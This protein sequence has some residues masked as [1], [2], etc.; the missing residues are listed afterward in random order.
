MD[1][2]NTNVLQQSILEAVDTIVSRRVKEVNYDKTIVG[3]INSFAEVRNKRNVYKINYNGGFFNAI[4]LNEADSYIP[5]TPVYIHV[6]QGDFTKEKIILSKASNIDLNSKLDILN[7]VSN[8][9][10]TIGKNNLIELDST[11]FPI[12]LHSYHSR[13]N[14]ST[15]DP[16]THRLQKLYSKNSENNI[17]SIEN[18]DNLKRY[19]N[20]KSASALMIRADF[21]TYLPLEQKRQTA[22]KYGLHFVL[23]FNNTSSDWGITQWDALNKAGSKIKAK[24]EFSKEEISFNSY[25]DK[26]AK[27]IK[28][29]ENS[30]SEIDLQ[31][32]IFNEDSQLH[33]WLNEMQALYDIFINKPSTEDKEIIQ[34]IIL[35]FFTELNSYFSF[36][37]ENIEDI[38]ESFNEWKNIKLNTE[39]DQIVHLELNSNKMVGSPL[40][41]QNWTS[42]Y[43]IF[44]L[45]LSN[46][47][48]IE[49]IYFYKDG[50][51]SSLFPDKD[52]A[53]IF[54]KNIGFYVLKPLD[55]ISGDYSLKVESLNT[56]A[57]LSTAHNE[58]VSFQANFYRKLEDLSQNTKLTYYWFKEDPSI[59]IGEKYYN[60]YG[61]KGWK[62]IHDLSY[63]SRYFT[64]DIFENEAYKNLYKCVAVFSEN[65]DSTVIV[66]APFT[67][68]NSDYGSVIELSTDSESIFQTP[69]IT[70]LING[71]EI[72]EITD[73]QIEYPLKFYWSLIPKDKEEIF[74][75]EQP[76]LNWTNLTFD[77][78]TT[79]INQDQYLKNIKFYQ[80]ENIL[81]PAAVDGK[82]DTTQAT[83]IRYPITNLSP[84]EILTIKCTVVKVLTKNNQEENSQEIIEVLLGTG[85]TKLENRVTGTVNGYRIEFE[86]DNQVFQYDEY[87]NS[88]ALNDKLDTL[89]ILPIRARLIG[90][91]GLEI[92]GTNVK[93]DWIF[94]LENTMIIP[95]EEAVL[96]E[97]NTKKILSNSIN[98][99]FNI[100]N[101]YNSNAINNQITCHINFNGEDYYKQTNLFFRKIGENGSNGTDITVHIRPTSTTPL[102]DSQPLTLYTFNDENNNTLKGFLNDKYRIDKE[103]DFKD[104]IIIG[105]DS[106]NNSGEIP[107]LT[108]DVFQKGQPLMSDSYINYWNL[109]GNPSER[110]ISKSKNFVLNIDEDNNPPILQWYYN[111]NNN[112]N[113]NYYNI[114]IIKSHIVIS[115][116]DKT[117]QEYYG[118]YPLPIIYYKNKDDI[119]EF[120]NNRLG[121]SKDYYLKEVTYNADGRNPIYNHNQG[122]KIINLPDWCNESNIKIIA[123]GGW[124]KEEN[125]PDF[126]ILEEETIFDKEN[127][128]IMIYILPNDSCGGSKTNNRIEVNIYQE[129]VN[130]QEID[131]EETNNQE[132]D[133]EEI[134]PIIT[135]SA[136]IIFILNTFGLASLNAWDGNSITIDEDGGYIMAPQIGA[137]EKDFNN[138]F[139]GIVM[140]KTET[141]TGGVEDEKQI[142]LFGYSNGLQSIFLD[143]ETGNAT[144]GLPDIEEREDE[145]GNLKKFYKNSNRETED[146]YREG[147][148]EL[149]PG[150]ISNIG[151]WHIGRKSLYYTDDDG[152]LGNKNGYPDP[153]YVLTKEGTIEEDISNPYSAHH[154]KDIAHD[155]SGIL[156]YGGQNPYI[157]I[158]SKPLT[159]DEISNSDDSLLKSKDS[160]ELQ[161]DPNTPTLFTIFRH[162]G[163]LRKKDENNI[164]TEESNILYKPNT[165][166]FLAGINSKGEFVANS[167]TNKSTTF[168]PT[169]EGGISTEI[170][171]ITSKFYFNTFPAFDDIIEA[172][173][174]IGFQMEAN[175]KVIGQL[176][177]SLL[178]ISDKNTDIPT[179]YISGGNSNNSD[180]GEY[181]KKLSLHGREIGLFV[182]DQDISE[183]GNI[184]NKRETNSNII[185]NQ[186]LGQIQAGSQDNIFLLSNNNNEHSK[187]ATLQNFDAFIGRNVDAEYQEEY[188]KIFNKEGDLVEEVP[189][190]RFGD[191]RFFKLNGIKNEDPQKKTLDTTSFYMR[192]FM[193]NE[194]K[195]NELYLL[196]VIEE[197]DDENSEIYY[198]LIS[199]PIN[200]NESYYIYN[201]IPISYDTYNT[202]YL[203][204]NINNTNKYILENTFLSNLYNQNHQSITSED[205]TTTSLFA[206]EKENASNYYKKDKNNQN[207]YLKEDYI[208]KENNEFDI[209]NDKYNR[210]SDINEYFKYCEEGQTPEYIVKFRGDY[211]ALAKDLILN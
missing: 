177:T 41:F 20:E 96:D 34:K 167:I 8:N 111:N 47:K 133:Q 56:G 154:D 14:E 61:G 86:N 195:E 129:E 144:F 182:P 73:N 21:R 53:D 5:N 26:I 128:S 176:F 89:K 44:Q 125:Q 60:E 59:K 179:L 120:A 189:L 92:S 185:L 201:N 25:I 3:T 88:P 161:L 82:I 198:N 55:N 94:N 78:F 107:A 148:I 85:E 140:G 30:D 166:T 76:D 175:K 112:N 57:I 51:V 187:L 15:L 19:L 178:D 130:N 134:K 42:Q 192:T 40:Y 160:L 197:E 123:K 10:T 143:A 180:W 173:Y 159:E 193:Q 165:R 206:V 194:I 39:E 72:T 102:L 200:F 83:Q 32:L 105:I 62:L 69:G 152:T 153:D 7:V 207:W 145:N 27:A 158:K 162:N 136:P 90:P 132:T 74:I 87:G 168:L 141:Y 50:F 139:T 67:V 80:K 12:G 210:L 64:T 6:P 103:N 98:C 169:S 4:V 65:Q 49:E 147:R 149:R 204:Y 196:K 150:D 199:H 191:S 46:F 97:G 124:S 126:T 142:G 163:S 70:C 54:I 22:A 11:Q 68:Y 9:F 16:S 116:K 38:I 35:A 172:P 137:G 121:I 108:V 106:L 151:G 81:E 174:H 113:N 58:E 211:S 170:S 203:R 33:V 104:T 52:K 23:R 188:L 17:I 66:N 118:Y 45:D 115:Q 127:H 18:I 155:K 135:I 209:K 138:R 122:L 101:L 183:T 71:Q 131:Q 114:Q 43:A 48:E 79:Y 146:N 2:A 202:N 164:S 208:K 84:D 110:S 95:P 29:I 100:D 1:N 109:A 36:N 24:T 119:S 93:I 117:T 63:N 184:K 37:A 91:N 99:I 13:M 156:L 190:S 186:D 205:I 77:S 28:E 157:S 171:D 181:F 31:K 75:Y